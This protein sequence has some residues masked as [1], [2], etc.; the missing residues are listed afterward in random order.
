MFLHPNN[1]AFIVQ[2]FSFLQTE[3]LQMK[4]RKWVIMEQYLVKKL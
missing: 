2:L 4:A 1:N 3:E